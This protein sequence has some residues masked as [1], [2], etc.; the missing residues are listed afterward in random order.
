[1][2]LSCRRLKAVAEDALYAHNRD[3][4]FSSAVD[5]AAEHGNITTL[6]KAFKHKLVVD[7]TDLSCTPVF[8][9]FQTAVAHGQDSAVAWFLD[10]GVDVTR[11]VC[12]RCCLDPVIERTC[13]LHTAIC[14]GHASTAQLLISRGAPLEYSYGS[15]SIFDESANAL[16]EASSAGLDALVET[17]FKDHGMT[18]QRVR[19]TWNQDALAHAAMLDKNVSTVRTLVGLGADV[20]W[21]HSDWGSSPLHIAIEEGNFAVAHTLLDLGAKVQPYEYETDID[22]NI[23][24]EEDEEKT[25][26][27]TIQV[28]VEPLY[29]LIA[30]RRSARQWDQPQSPVQRAEAE[31]RRAERGRFMKRLIDLG[32]DVNKRAEGSWQGSSPLGLATEVGD[33]QDMTMLIRAGAEVKSY[34]L[35]LAWEHIDQPQE[36]TA[37]ISL[38]LKHGARLDQ[39]IKNGVK[40]MLQVAAAHLDADAAHDMSGLHEILLLSSPKSLSS[41]H[42]DEVL[43]ECLARHRWY[44]STVLVRHGARVLCQDKL[45]SIASSIAEELKCEKGG[46]DFQGFESEITY[47]DGLHDCIR[48]VIDMGLSSQDKCLIFQD[49]LRKRQCTLAHLFLDRGLASLPEAAVFL[50]AYLM[51]AASWGNICVIKRLWQHAHEASDAALRYSLVQ[52]SIIS[53][54]RQAVSFFMEHG[55]TPFQHLTPTEA[56]RERLMRKDALEAHL[57][58]LRRSELSSEASSADISLRREYKGTQLLT[59]RHGVCN[60]GSTYLSAFLSAFLSPLQSAVRYGHV[61]IVNDLLDYIT[62]SDAGAITKCGKIYIPCVLSRANETREMIQKKGIDCDSGQ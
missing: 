24:G 60:Y 14:R 37:K 12:P 29:V 8:S 35:L 58:A 38:L 7:E 28:H 48:F 27:A 46:N 36:S 52:Q 40:S 62:Q 47:D 23:E 59:A 30:Q 61:D 50:P 31:F 5:W 3:H 9:P 13:I 39:P 20:N 19:G 21:F 43:T 55:A 42:L 1:M 17:L 44:A 57:T 4:G 15:G 34:M 49:I 10:H 45:F 51:L 56:R 2:A 18:L 6:D 25:T 16:L 41:D 26:P 22:L 11:E 33:L 54:N 53:G 32:V